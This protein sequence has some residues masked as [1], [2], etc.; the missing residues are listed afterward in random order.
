MTLTRAPG[1]GQTLTCGPAGPTAL[2]L[3][4]SPG[5]GDG[6]WSHASLCQPSQILRLP[7]EA[8][9]KQHVPKLPFIHYDLLQGENRNG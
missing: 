3:W 7:G 9:E 6:A 4:G 8:E 2:G 1:G 5:R